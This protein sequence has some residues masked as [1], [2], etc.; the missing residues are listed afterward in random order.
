MP[1]YCVNRSEQPNGDHEVHAEGCRYWPHPSNVLPLG[2]HAS[3]QPAVQAARVYYH[4]VN[5][6]RTCSLPCHTQ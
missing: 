5:G 3:C 1:Q 6:C 4:Q 2:W